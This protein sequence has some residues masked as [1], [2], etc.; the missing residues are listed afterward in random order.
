[1]SRARRGATIVKGVRERGLAGSA[2]HLVPKRSTPGAKS[3]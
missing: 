3:I 1:M 2:A